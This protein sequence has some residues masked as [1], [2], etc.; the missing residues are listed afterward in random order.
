MGHQQRLG[1]NAVR[2]CEG[3]RARSSSSGIARNAEVSS[4]KCSKG[5]IGLEFKFGGQAQ[6]FDPAAWAEV[7]TVLRQ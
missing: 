2:S 3:R 4:G 1:R 6:S 7:A 5:V